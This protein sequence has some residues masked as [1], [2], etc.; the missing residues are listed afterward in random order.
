MIT[1][2]LVNR[3]CKTIREILIVEDSPILSSHLKKEI[4]AYF[5]FDCDLSVTK[6][7][8][9]E[10]IRH[11]RYD[12][13]I[14]DINLPECDG[15]LIH[16]LID[17]DQQ[18]VMM[19]AENDEERREKLLALPIVDYVI[20]SDAKT[21]VSY[22]IKTIQR[23]N[24]NRKTIVGVCDDSA[25]A[26]RA[27]TFMLELQNLP[28]IE[29]EDGQQV[30]NHLSSSGVKMDLLLTDYHMPDID[31]LELVRRIRHAYLSED[32]PIISVSASEKPHI[33]AQF[34]K[35][36]ANDYLPKNAENEEFLTR[37]NLTLDYLYTHRRN[38][39]LVEELEKAATHDFLTQLYN[40]T[41]FFSQIPHIM[42][43]AIRRKKPYGILMLDIDHFKK[44]NDIYGHHI[45]DKAIQHI[46]M[47]LK[48]IARRS[49]FCF[50]WGGEEFI[51]LIP[52]VKTSDELA[53]FG[54]RIRSVIEK[55]K[56]HID[57]NDLIFQITVSIG[58]A[59]GWEE[60]A[61]YLLSHADEMLYEA[62]KSGRNCVKLI[63]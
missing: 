60:E 14:A 54:E 23:L 56:V 6:K 36:G 44:I 25:A 19:T 52:E 28:Y 59:C 48:D 13:I 30:I 37:L 22:L 27:I 62:K 42:A 53:Q 47:V 34:L 24:T 43:N 31:G 38:R 55:S 63:S 41:Y 1:N 8:A 2:T 12:L 50:R 16:Q 51:I 40:R 49:D 17:K 18:V 32:F 7:E 20:K 9:Q 57:E 5:S 10:K 61:E 39:L 58:G 46:A 4:D 26:R 11:K 21:L 35:A 29:F 15:E 33:L 3:H 45:G